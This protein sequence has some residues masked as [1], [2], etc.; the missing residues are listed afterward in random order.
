MLTDTPGIHH[1]TG[2]VR[3]AQTNVNFYTDV[4]GLR[5]IKQTVN[6]NEKFTRHLFYGD[7]T[8]SPG[9]GLTFFPYPAEND[10]RIGKPQISTAALVIP[11]NSVSYWRDRLVEHDVAVTGPTERFDETV[12][13][14]SDPDGTKLELVTGDSSVTPWADGPVPTQH[15]IRGIFGVTLLSTNIFVTAS[16][17]ETL[18]FE[19]L[20]QAGDRVRYRA[21]GDRATVI[22]LLDRDVEFG[23]E[24]AG[25]IHHVAVRVPEKEQLYEWHDLFREREY[26]VSRVKDRHFF[27][28]L[29]VRE[30]GGIL[31][32]LATEQPGL[33]ADADLDTLGQ[34]LFLPP[35]L[36]EDREMIEGQLQPLELPS[37]PETN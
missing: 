19:L 13:R 37:A 33:T 3:D 5:L 24:G 10:G 20:E 2:I 29:Y 15:A 14:V 1:I 17:L 31:F 9:T 6:F 18:G 36:E 27:H 25:S 26:D 32:E 11:P 35:W 16:V 28:S 7:E 34:S 21:P 22:D 4:L 30:P 8:G 12:L 23:R